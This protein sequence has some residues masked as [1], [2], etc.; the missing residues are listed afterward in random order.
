MNRPSDLAVA[1]R[2]FPKGTDGW[3]R[4]FP[5]P[6]AGWLTSTA[7][8][9][10]SA[11]LLWFSFP[12]LEWAWVAWF[13]LVPLGMLLRAPRRSRPIYVPAWLGGLAFGLLA[14]QWLRYAD[15]SGW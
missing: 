4:A 9:T 10:S 14:V 13:A 15:D 5:A 7:L 11:L 1:P 8:A 3:Q 2:P 12:P 6:A